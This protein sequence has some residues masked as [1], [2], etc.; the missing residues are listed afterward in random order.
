[1]IDKAYL[2]DLLPILRLNGVTHIKMQ[3]IELSFE[4]KNKFH[5]E[6]P[7]ESTESS[8]DVLVDALRKQEEA[9][10][11]DLRADTLMDQD[12]ILNWSSPDQGPDEPELPLTGEQP[13]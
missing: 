10:P 6:H 12:K 13:L 8:T 3:G 4:H 5:V 2:A 11:V 1:M 9:M 7:Q